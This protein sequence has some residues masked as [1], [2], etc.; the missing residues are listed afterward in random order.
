LA[1]STYQLAALLGAGVLEAREDHHDDH[2]EHQ[3]QG[4]A[5]QERHGAAH[6]PTPRRAV[7][8]RVAAFPMRRRCGKSWEEGE[9]LWAPS[10]RGLPLPLC[11]FAL[12]FAEG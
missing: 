11:L 3:P 10:A 2:S 12:C 1:A 9:R 6:S 4:G 8:G 5:E 7:R